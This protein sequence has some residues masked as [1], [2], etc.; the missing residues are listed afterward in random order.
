MWRVSVFVCEMRRE[1]VHTSLTLSLSLSRTLSVI[2]VDGEISSLSLIMATVTAAVVRY[3]FD[4]VPSRSISTSLSIAELS[5]LSLRTHFHA[6]DKGENSNRLGPETGDD[7]HSC[8]HCRAS[9]WLNWDFVFF[10][11]RGQAG[12]CRNDLE[13]HTRI[14][15]YICLK[16][17]CPHVYTHI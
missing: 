13:R 5:S 15:I 3:R 2:E 6:L 12:S 17:A 11:N 10:R 1:T 14:Y 4:F 9:W 16:S 7:S 8:L